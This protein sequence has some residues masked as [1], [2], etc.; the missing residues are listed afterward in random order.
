MNKTAITVRWITRILSVLL[1]LLF[2]SDIVADIFS[3]A[4]QSQI[5]RQIT[6]TASYRV[7]YAMMMLSL[8]GLAVAWRWELIGSIVSLTAIVVLAIIIPA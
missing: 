2:G 7:G 8:V 5:T 6:R 3:S 4:D 1:I